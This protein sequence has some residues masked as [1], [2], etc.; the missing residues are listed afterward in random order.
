MF[1]VGGDWW[2]V[3]LFQNQLSVGDTFPAMVKPGLGVGGTVVEWCFYATWR[4]YFNYLTTLI[5]ELLTFKNP[6]L[7]SCLQ[8]W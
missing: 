5:K 1:R 3:E 7:L 8:I 6:K 2:G 4:F